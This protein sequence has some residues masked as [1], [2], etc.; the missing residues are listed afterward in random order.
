MCSVCNMQ[1]MLNSAIIR[2]LWH[3]IISIGMYLWYF[4]QNRNDAKNVRP[5]LHPSLAPESTRWLAIWLRAG[6]F[7]NEI[8]GYI[9]SVARKN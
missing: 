4:H 2:M 5:Y 6:G 7:S 3:V 8:S 9:Y 1:H